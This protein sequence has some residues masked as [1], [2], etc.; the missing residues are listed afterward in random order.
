[1]IMGKFNLVAIMVVVM[2]MIFSV[3]DAEIYPDCSYICAKICSGTPTKT[4]FD[5]CRKEYC[6]DLPPPKGE[7]P[8]TSDRK[9]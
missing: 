3:T 4:C 9:Y 2:L 8:V 6:I 7:K 1:M 5:K